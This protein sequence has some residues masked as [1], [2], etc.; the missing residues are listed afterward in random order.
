MRKI[1][2][3]ILL[4]SKFGKA[5]AQ[6]KYQTGSAEF[7]LPIFQWEDDKSRLASAVSL[8]YSSGNGLKVADMASNV[9]QGWHLQIGGSITRIQSGEPDD[10]KPRDG[11]FDDIKKY[12]PGYLYDPISAIEGCP[13][14]LTE[15]PIFDARNKIYKNYNEVTADKELDRFAFEINGRSGVFCL[16][17]NN[18]DKGILIGDGKLK[19]WFTRNE[20]MPSTRTTI[21]AFFIQDENGIIYKFNKLSV[22]KALK[23]RYS[24][25]GGNY[26]LE[27]P[28][29]EGDNVYHESSF[30]DG[31]LANPYIVNGW[32]LTEMED[33]ITHR[34]ILFNYVDRSINTSA[35]ENFAAY[36]EK[37]Y[38]IITHSKSIGTSSDISSMVYPDGHTVTVNYGAARIDFNGQFAV[39]SLDVQY[40]GRFISK[41]ELNT[42]YF[43]GNRIGIPTTDYQKSLARLCLTSIKKIGIDLMSDEAPYKFEYNLGSSA[44]DDIVPAPFSYR[45][46][47]WGYYNGDNSRGYAGQQFAINKRVNELTNNEVYGLCFLRQNGY[48]AIINPNGGYAKN[49]LLKKIMY[50]TGG[51]LK[52]EYEQNTGLLNGQ[53]TPIGGVHVSKSITSDDG[54]NYNCDETNLTTHYKY[55]T[56]N[57]PNE[58]SI[59]GV[60]NPIN[61]FTSSAYYN[62]MRKRYKWGVRGCGIFGCCKYK[63]LHPGILS[64]DQAIDLTGH[65]QF[66]QALSDVLDA[67]SLV[68]TV[69]NIINIA[70]GPTG[71]G[72]IVAAVIDVIVGIFVLIKTCTK[73]Y[74]KWVHSNTY[75][76]ADLNNNPLPIQYSRVEV[77]ANNGENGR[78]VMEFTSPQDYPIWYPTNLALS[79]KQRFAYWAYGLPK[80]TTVYDA[81]GKVV[82]ESENVYDYQY[83]RRGT[84]EIFDANGQPQTPTIGAVSCKCLVKSS[85]SNRSDWW[86]D[87]NIGTPENNPAYYVKDMTSNWSLLADI[88]NI[89][90]GR[91]ELRKTIERV[92]STTSTALLE[93]STTY[94]Y[95]KTYLPTAVTTTQSNGD[96]NRKTTKYTGDAW[97]FGTNQGSA[98]STLVQNNVLNLPVVTRNMVTKATDNITYD[99]SETITDYQPVNGDVKPAKILSKRLDQPI[100]AGIGYQGPLSNTTDYKVIKYFKYDN[101]ANLSNV[102]GELKNSRQAYLYDYND[103]YITATIINAGAS[104][105]LSNT[106]G[107]FTLMQE[108]NGTAYTSF[109]TDKQNGWFLNLDPSV[110]NTYAQNVGVTGNRALKLGYD[111]TKSIIAPDIEIGSGV[112]YGYGNY[113][114]STLSFWATAPVGVSPYLNGGSPA[115]TT[116]LVIT[117]PTINGFTYYQYKIENTSGNTVNVQLGNFT[118]GVA[119]ILIDELR[120]YRSDARMQTS[121]YDPLL[122][123]TSECDENNRITYY[124]Y[125]EKGRIRFVKDEKSNVVKMY[126]YN[127]AT[128]QAVNC[129]GQPPV[130]FTNFATSEVFQK[131]PCRGYPYDMPSSVTYTI[132][133]GTYISTISQAVVDL[134]VQQDLQTNGQAYANANGICIPLFGNSIQSAAFTKEDCEVGYTGTII[135]YT[136]PANRYYATSMAA[137]NILATEE[138]NANGQAFAN[139]P[140]NATCI[141]DLLPD[142][143]GVDPAVTQCGTGANVGHLMVQVIDINPNSSSYGSTQWTDGGSSAA[144]GGTEP[145]YIDI[146]YTNVNNVQATIKLKNLSSLVVYTLNAA[147]NT[148][149]QTVA[150]FVPVGNYEVTV[151][152]P[153]GSNAHTISVYN[154]TQMNSFYQANVT[155]GTSALPIVRIT[156]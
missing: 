23:V 35:G 61:K 141:I 140:G 147:P 130:V 90:T 46:D 29:M 122:G 72:A 144:C 85:R 132:P 49:G 63:Y 137:A 120:L 14:K 52:Y 107:A 1:F 121:T 82:K 109:E 108:A 8:S 77:I 78:T 100:A 42:Q 89:Q 123:K 92:A 86:M 129:P 39:K 60:E 131:Q 57:N 40:G 47:I 150:G 152:L 142:W 88:Y 128:K 94:E 81:F 93:N 50:P 33:A 73:D 126:E 65:Q 12:P 133:A 127:N 80:K 74:S 69:V 17:K 113:G 59:W 83:A 119:T 43:I 20:N 103:K 10:Q 6:V 155:V 104:N 36:S 70:L 111:G 3:F 114:S 116:T 21:N 7:G 38:S 146:T 45:K 68:M 15:Y 28:T 136:I 110:I 4:F 138:L 66:L 53:Q 149:T 34:K 44:A 67:V 84:M 98:L 143:E 37:G 32:M 87:M 5:E 41:Y 30:D 11:N 153:F 118:P 16:N 124:E 99:L 79:N 91:V 22:A 9:G 56:A 112:G 106:Y 26:P 95:G 96:I 145:T 148:T 48:A 62:P 27:Q 13:K 25:P 135:T 55:T 117:G 154:T 31:S 2:I 115:P 102:W 105:T 76:N 75:Y 97:Q 71:V 58:S 64:R 24:D 139:A 18:G 151:T 51:S 125:D 54:N 19:I 101:T 156:L 134:L